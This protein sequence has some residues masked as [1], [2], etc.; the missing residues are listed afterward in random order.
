MRRV[1]WVLALVFVSWGCARQPEPLVV[2]YWYLDFCHSCRATR[3]GLTTLAA[4]HGDLELRLIDH[5]AP[6]AEEAIRAQ[7]FKRHGLLVTRGDTVVLKQ[8]DHRV[9]LADVQAVV[10]AETPGLRRAP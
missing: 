9:R 2:T 1:G 10:S 7:G 5:R 6:G 8:A 4:S 3:E